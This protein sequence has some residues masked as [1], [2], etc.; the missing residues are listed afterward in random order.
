M[1]SNTMIRQHQAWKA[2]ILAAGFGTRLL[3]YTE[4][5]PK[6]IF[7]VGG[8]PIIDRTIRYLID[9]G[10]GEILIN[11]HHLHHRIEAFIN[12]GKYPIPVQTRYEPEILGT[13]G[14]IKNAADFFGQQ[15]F[16]VLN[17]D[18]ITDIPLEKVYAFHCSHAESVT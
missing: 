11:T 17:S 3:P 5:T 14:G 2:M 8:Q 7:P 4:H 6:A 10:C 18:I 9:A 12:A 15:P 16:V 1:D 13:G